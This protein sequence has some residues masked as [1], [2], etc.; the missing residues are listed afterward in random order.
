M[1]PTPRIRDR[2]RDADVP[3]ALED[4]ILRALAPRKADR[5]PTSEAFLNAL[6]ELYD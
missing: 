6:N 5:W 1:Q 3:A 2:S 4:A